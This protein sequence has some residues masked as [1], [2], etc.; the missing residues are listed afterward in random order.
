MK[1]KTLEELWYEVVE[2]D[3]TL[4]NDTPE[5]QAAYE[6]MKKAIPALTDINDPAEAAAHTW[7]AE[8]TKNGFLCGFRYASLLWADVISGNAPE[9]LRP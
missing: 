4:F 2:Q 7:A 3:G 8:C 1:R 9:G 6:A 5:E